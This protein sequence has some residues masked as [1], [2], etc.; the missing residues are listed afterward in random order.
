MRV[1]HFVS[2]IS[3]TFRLLTIHAV[4]R[5]YSV[6]KYCSRRGLDYFDMVLGVDRLDNADHRMM[7]MY[8]SSYYKGNMDLQIWIHPFS[9]IHSNCN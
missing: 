1:S 7:L 6:N 2:E 3:S 5:K 9:Y 4:I 8:R